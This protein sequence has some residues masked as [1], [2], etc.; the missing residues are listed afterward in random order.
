ME[1]NKNIY[2]NLLLHPFFETTK[3]IQ[4]DIARLS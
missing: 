4:S 1:E 2:T 3:E